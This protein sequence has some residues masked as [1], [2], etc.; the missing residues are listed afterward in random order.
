MRSYE[1]VVVGLLVA[2]PVPMASSAVI[3]SGYDFAFA[4]APFADP[5]LEANQDRLTSSVWLTRGGTRGIYNAAVEPGYQGSGTSG[6]SPEGTLWAFGTTDEIA[7]LTFTSWAVAADRNPP[8]LVGRDM[9][10]H[11]VADDVFVDIRFS[12][13]DERAGGGGGFS[14]VRGVPGPGASVALGAAGALA[15]GRRRRRTGP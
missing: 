5:M 1:M 4:K 6:P 3:W 8:G 7:S 10:V 9:V 13:W 12:D 14:Y 11:L 2:G 15:A